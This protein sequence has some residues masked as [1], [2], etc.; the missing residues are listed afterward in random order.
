MVGKDHCEADSEGRKR[1]TRLGR[2]YTIARGSGL[3]HYMSF[4]DVNGD[5]LEDIV[6][7][8]EEDGG[9][10]IS[11]YEHPPG[12][13]VREL[14]R[15]HF[16]VDANFTKAFARDLDQDGDVDFIGTGEGYDTGDFGWLER[17][18]SGYTLREFDIADNKNDVA[19]G[20][21]CD[22]VD[23]DS[24]GDE[25][26]IVGGVDKRDGKQRFRWYEYT[27]E[28][29]EVRWKEHV[30]G[31]TS[32]E[33][34]RP[35]HGYYCGEMAWGDMDGDG[36]RDFVFAG[37]GGGFLGW[38]ENQGNSESRTDGEFRLVQ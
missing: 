38:F 13:D 18:D 19:G 21:N 20:H 22:L 35:A 6:T 24:D 31:V 37:H 28:A 9:E 30:F 7:A 4:H 16:V 33:G 26:L 15:K 27:K 32:S 3:T 12:D 34:F 11:W 5:G 17:T 25:D 1:E 36:D 8:K 10:G 23:V 2:I 29:G 14:W